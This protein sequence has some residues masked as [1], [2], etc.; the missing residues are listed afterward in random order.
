MLKGSMAESYFKDLR[1]LAL[2]TRHSAQI[3]GIVRGYGGEALVVPAVREM[4]LESQEH[5]LQFAAGLMRGDFDL[6]IFLT[7][8]G[9]RTLVDVVAARYDREQ[10]LAALRTVK[11]AARGPKPAAVLRELNI[12]VT[13]TAPQPCTWRELML[14]MEEEFGSDLRSMFR[15]TNGLFRKTCSPS[16]NACW[17]WPADRSMSSSLQ[18]LSR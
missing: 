10:F 5:A 4:Q 11:I 16:G 18:Q 3:A 15:S 14:A 9:V 17:L 6:V 7:E 2:E 12:P 13:V 8:L 1:I